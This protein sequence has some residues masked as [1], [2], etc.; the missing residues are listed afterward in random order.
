MLDVVISNMK[1]LPARQSTA[2]VP[3]HHQTIFPN[4]RTKLCGLEAYKRQ[5]KL[6]PEA[7]SPEEP[8]F[9]GFKTLTKETPSK[10]PAYATC[11]G[12]AKWVS[13]IL[14]RSVTFKDLA[15][16]PVFTKLANEMSVFDAAKAVGVRPQT[17]GRYHRASHSDVSRRAAEVLCN[18]YLFFNKLK[19]IF[20]LYFSHHK[21]NGRKLNQSPKLQTQRVTWSQK[22]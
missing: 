22:R 11:M 17:I 3:L 9:R 1:N 2:S 8:F 5:I 19:F 4:S 13:G 18:V 7:V 10:A 20:L 12:A 15:R 16:R 14:G 6:L 21:K